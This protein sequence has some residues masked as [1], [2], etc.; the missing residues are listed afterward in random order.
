M[1]ER[2]VR[3]LKEGTTIALVHDRVADGMT[4]F[5]KRFGQTFDGPPFDLRTLDEYIPISAEDESSVHQFGIWRERTPAR[6]ER[7][8]GCGMEMS[9]GL[10]GD[11][12]LVSW[13]GVCCAV[14]NVWR[15]SCRSNCGQSVY[16]SP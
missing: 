2:A 5:E 12:E 14:R 1:V 7:H 11:E 10:M 8:N 15:R 6:C 16:V 13:D 9:V 3:R 4:A